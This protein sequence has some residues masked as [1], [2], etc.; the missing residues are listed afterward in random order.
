M[1]FTVDIAGIA[2]LIAS[3]IALW[4]AFK[5]T[6]VEM[7]GSRANTVKVFEEAARA[8]GERLVVVEKRLEELGKERDLLEAKID[9][10]EQRVKELEKER[11]ELLGWIDRLQHQISA[12]GEKPV[13]RVIQPRKP[14]A[15][16]AKEH[17]STD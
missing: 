4:K 12:L 6:P 2:A 16:G 5:Q 13:P 1:N 8:A 11:D 9:M 10:S 3:L 7:N 14:P 15:K 17:G